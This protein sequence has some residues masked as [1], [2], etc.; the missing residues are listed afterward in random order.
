VA[1]S[2]RVPAPRSGRSVKREGR[3]TARRSGQAAARIPLLLSSAAGAPAAREAHLLGKGPESDEFGRGCCKWPRAAAG[4]L[5][6]RRPA[7]AGWRSRGGRS[8]NDRATTPTE[9]RVLSV[10]GDIPYARNRVRSGSPSIAVGARLE[11]TAE[12]TAR[13]ETGVTTRSR[14]RALPLYVHL[15]H[16][17]DMIDRR[18][19]DD[20]D[21]AAL[22]AAAWLSQA[23][24]IRAFHRAFGEPPH[25]YLR[26]RRVERAMELLRRGGVRVTDVALAVGFATP[27]SFATA[28]RELVGETPSAY[29]ARWHGVAEP[30][31]PG[32]FI[33]MY[34][35]PPKAAVFGKRSGN[36]ARTVAAVP[37]ARSDR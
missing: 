35:A 32:C 7:L 3:V 36:S 18:Y 25:R 28:F 10:D 33:R 4:E 37:D 34:L 14:S 8:V 15:R 9:S 17:K 1:V 2:A 29:A 11:P 24:F 23:H 26:R 30:A 16:A 6:R 13:A 22:A 31:I 27:S 21:V 12:S 20:L 5:A 19:A